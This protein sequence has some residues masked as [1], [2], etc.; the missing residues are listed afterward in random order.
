VAGNVGDPGATVTSRILALLGAFDEGHRSLT[1]S[2]LARRADL[3][4]TTTHR[5]A[6]EL[7]AHGALV[8]TDGGDYV[9]G[10]RLWSL[11]LLAPMQTGLVET[12]SP[13][14][15]DLYAATWATVHLAVRDHDEVL[16]LDRIS[17]RR[18]VPVVSTVGSRLPLHATGVGKVLLAH[19]PAEVQAAVLGSLRRITPY[20]HT[21]PAR[22]SE[23]P[24]ELRVQYETLRW[25]R[26]EAQD[27]GELSPRHGR[28]RVCHRLDRRTGTARRRTLF[29]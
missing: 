26:D 9:V 14:L 3:P 28:H 1:V 25:G 4:L 16:Y 29:P 20:P 10:R 23:Q 22:L 17:G 11:G 15:H 13:F 6:R 2:E 27:L 18:S 24:F 21:Q 5:L 19:A 8:R 7:V 12:A